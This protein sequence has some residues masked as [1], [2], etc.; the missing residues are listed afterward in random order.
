MVMVVGALPDMVK[1]IYRNSVSADFQGQMSQ[2]TLQQILARDTDPEAV[3]VPGKPFPVPVLAELNA[4][5]ESQG[6]ARESNGQNQER[7]PLESRGGEK[8]LSGP[9][10][11]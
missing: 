6:E 9:G 10:D 4:S 1:H 7:W 2:S 8:P 5:K 3:A 11:K